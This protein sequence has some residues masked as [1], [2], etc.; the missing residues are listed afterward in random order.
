MVLDI[1][2]KDV[3][4]GEVQDEPRGER[5]R[6]PPEVAEIGAV[7]LDSKI[8]QGNGDYEIPHSPGREQ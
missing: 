7:I 1:D 2:I 6:H 3:T 4:E 5:A 8:A